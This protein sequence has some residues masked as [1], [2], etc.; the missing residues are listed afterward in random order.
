MIQKGRFEPPRHTTEDDLPDVITNKAITIGIT[1]V[2]ESFAW[3]V[4]MT[5]FIKNSGLHCCD[6]GDFPCHRHPPE[7]Q[8]IGFC[9]VDKITKQIGCHSIKW[10]NRITLC[11]T[12]DFEQGDDHCQYVLKAYQKEPLYEGEMGY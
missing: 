12:C 4:D 1:E 11:K 5:D 8:R 7:T 6:C 9:Y 2:K 3:M 10:P